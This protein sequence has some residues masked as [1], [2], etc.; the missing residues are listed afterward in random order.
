MNKS[1]VLLFASLVALSSSAESTMKCSRK[2]MEKLPEVVAVMN[3]AQVQIKNE[4]A[5]VLTRLGAQFETNDIVVNERAPGGFWANGQS[6]LTGGVALKDGTGVRF[7][8]IIDH[9]VFSVKKYDALGNYLGKF[10]DFTAW[11]SLGIYNV[12]TG[13]PL[14]SVSFKSETISVHR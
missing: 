5:D 11:P 6:T 8:G 4:I 9:S 1:I 14:G 10:C 7:D 13:N 2:S 12:S 3:G